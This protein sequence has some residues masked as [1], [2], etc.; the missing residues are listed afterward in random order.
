MTSCGKRKKER[1]NDPTLSHRQEGQ[2]L[3]HFSFLFYPQLIKLSLP[4]HSFIF[5]LTTH[6]QNTHFSSTGQPAHLRCRS[7]LVDLYS[8]ALPR[9]LISSSRAQHSSGDWKVSFLSPGQLQATSASG[10][11]WICHHSQPPHPCPGGKT[12]C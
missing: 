9:D 11:K 1:K 5:S 3:K 12:G 4:Y 6:P 8:V 2:I 10:T 7:S